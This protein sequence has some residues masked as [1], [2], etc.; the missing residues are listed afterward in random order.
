MTSSIQIKKLAPTLA[1]ITDVLYHTYIFLHNMGL[2]RM[3]HCS[4]NLH[5]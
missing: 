5:K 1:E 4:K 3:Q 2:L